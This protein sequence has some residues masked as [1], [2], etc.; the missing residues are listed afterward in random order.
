MPAGTEL[1]FGFFLPWN[2][3]IGTVIEL[4]DTNSYTCSSTAPLAPAY[5]EGYAAEYAQPASP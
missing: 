3:R 5:G 1:S 2:S 4:I